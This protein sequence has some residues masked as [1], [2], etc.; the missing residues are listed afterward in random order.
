M[1]RLVVLSL[2]FALVSLPA[3]ADPKPAQKQNTQLMSNVSKNRSEISMTFARNSRAR[4]AP[5]QS[6]KPGAIG[7]RPKTIRP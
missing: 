1:K 6:T 2:A 3:S 4:V 7:N 5:Q